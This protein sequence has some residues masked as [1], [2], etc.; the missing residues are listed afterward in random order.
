MMMNNSD[1]KIDKDE[2]GTV[3]E[4]LRRIK[5]SIKIHKVHLGYLRGLPLRQNGLR[6]MMMMMMN[7]YGEI[8]K[9]DN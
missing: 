6:I 3:Y 9:A 2:I 4:L 5:K 7:C 8:E 1:G